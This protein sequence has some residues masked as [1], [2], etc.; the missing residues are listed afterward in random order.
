M[1]GSDIGCTVHKGTN[2][3]VHIDTIHTEGVGEKHGRLVNV[4]L[5]NR[6]RFFPGKYERYVPGGGLSAW[7]MLLFSH[8][9]HTLST[10]RQLMNGILMR[11][12]VRVRGECSE[13]A[14][15]HES[16]FRVWLTRERSGRMNEY[17]RGSGAAFQRS[18]VDMQRWTSNFPNLLFKKK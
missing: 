1:S 8:V 14:A 18:H 17:W 5:N 11:P 10:E 4:R 6:S 12:F 13:A 7:E 3:Q 9:H 15:V 16:N 2:S